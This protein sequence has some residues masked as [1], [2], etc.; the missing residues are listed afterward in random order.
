MQGENINEIS[1][2]KIIDPKRSFDNLPIYKKQIILFAGPLMNLIIP[3]LLFPLIFIN[4]I[5]SPKYL[6]DKMV[7][8]SIN[9]DDNRFNEFKLDSEFIS[10]NDI[11]INNWNDFFNIDNDELN[12]KLN[13]GY[14]FN[15][16]VF[17]KDFDN[18]FE[19]IDFKNAFSPLIGSSA[20][21]YAVLIFACSYMP[22]TR[23]NLIF[24]DIRAPKK[25]VINLLDEA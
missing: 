4:G 17:Y 8:G 9:I 15:G 23:V 12:K 24:F 21:V 1:D 13:I 3:F 5:D 25:P 6:E 22:N 18:S 2:N 14:I 19:S 11:K 10:I 7:I 20:A 16:R